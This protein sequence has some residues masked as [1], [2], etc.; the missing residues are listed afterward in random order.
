MDI[1]DIVTKLVGP[2]NPVGESYEDDRRLK[3]LEEM[4]T[5]VDKLVFDIDRVS[6][7]RERVEYSRK[8]AGV[9]AYRF[10]HDLGI[11]D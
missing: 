4:I 3:N 10:L 8:R 11:E 6:V 7:E 5:L 1:Y 9:A 2:I